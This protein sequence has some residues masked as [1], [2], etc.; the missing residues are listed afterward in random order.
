MI[1]PANQDSAGFHTHGNRK[2]QEIYIVVHGEGEYLEKQRENLPHS[3][4]KF[5][6]G[7][8]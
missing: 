2:E 3:K 7:S 4:R 6:D 1:L 5:N 8:R